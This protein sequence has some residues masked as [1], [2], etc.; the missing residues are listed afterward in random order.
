MKDNTTGCTRE[1]IEINK[2]IKLFQDN[3]INVIGISK[4]NCESHKKFIE[5]YSLEFPLLCDTDLKVAEKFNVIN[6]KTVSGQIKLS[7][8]R[9]IFLFNENQNMVLRK[10][11]I[12]PE[13]AAEIIK[14]TF[15]T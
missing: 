11:K 9:S 15:L 10:D 12:K 7:V 5:K 8:Y 14:N 13:E 4:D 6:K 2:Y 3:N 1:A